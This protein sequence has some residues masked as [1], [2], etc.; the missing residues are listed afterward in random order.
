MY[1]RQ[2][3]FDGAFKQT[4]RETGRY[5]DRFDAFRPKSRRSNVGRGGTLVDSTPFVRRVVDSNPAL[6]AM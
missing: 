3:R 5:I 4:D 2:E 6:A 1:C